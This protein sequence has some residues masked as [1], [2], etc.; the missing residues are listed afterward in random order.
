MTKTFSKLPEF[1]SDDEIAAFMEEHDG[2]ELVDAGLAE[3]VPT[4]HFTRKR[5][6]GNS[7]LKD[8]RVRVAFK[9]EKSLRKIFS[10]APS[11]DIVFRVIDTD[12][13]G[14]LLVP[15]DSKTKETFYV[16]YL[17]ISAVEVL[18]CSKNA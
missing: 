15:L 16:P 11:S 2:F 9:D 5:N 17:N 3:I 8:R 6:V 1:R 13:Y 14:L 12:P 10:S 18:G 7:L 4:P